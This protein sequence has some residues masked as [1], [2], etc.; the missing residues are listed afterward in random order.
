M[1][2]YD[3]LRS[4]LE[5]SATALAERAGSLNKRRTEV[6]GSSV[7]ALRG[8]ERLRS[9]NANVPRD[10]SSI[11]G[12][13][14][15]AYNPAP[16]ALTSVK[17]NDIFAIHNL[18]RSSSGEMVL[19]AN[20]NGL[21]A[22]V[23]DDAQFRRDFDELHTYYK[24][25]RVQQLYRVANRMLAVF[26]IGT[27]RSDIRVL[28]WSVNP[29][30]S[31]Q[32]LD[33]RGERDHKAPARHDV[34][35]TLVTREDHVG[36]SHVSLSDRVLINPLNGTI[37]LMMPDRSLLLSDPVNHADQSLADCTIRWA[38]CGD[39]IV[40]DLLPYGEL[41]HRYYVANLLDHTATRID[42]LGQAFRQLPEGQG[43]IHPRGVFLKNGQ[44]QSF[45]LEADQMEL[46]EVVRSPNGEDMLYVFYEQESGRSILL[47]Y[48]VVRQEVTTP[49]RCDGHS[50]FADGTMVM[51]REEHEPTRI[52]PMQI[53]ETPFASDEWFAAQPREISDLDRI[54][55]AA[56]VRGIADALALSRLIGSIEPSSELYG[57][58]LGSV[59]RFLDQHHWAESVD[60]G[61]LA[62]PAR[63]MQ[64]VAGQVIDE[65]E[66]VLE[67]KAVATAT[68]DEA[69]QTFNQHH[70]EERISPPATTEAFINLLGL[71]R[72]D[73]GHLHSI[74]DQP[75]VDVAAVD[76]LV[77]EATAAHAATAQKAAGHLAGDGAFAPYHER[78]ARITGS[79]D[80]AGSSI[81]A[82]ELLEEVDGVAT[83][84]DV[85]SS[86]V[87]DL[88]VDDPRVRTSVLEQVSQ[89]LASLNQVRARVETKQESLI[90][91]ETGAS[92]ATELGLF[93][94]SI[95]SALSRVDEPKGCDE[96]LGRLLLQLEQ[97]ETAGPRSDEQIREL[98]LRREQV[99]ETVSARRQKLVDEREAKAQRLVG[100]A[101]R[102]L[103][104]ITERAA[105]LPSVDDVNGFFAADPMTARVR[106]LTDQLRELG[107]A[108]KA[109]ELKSQLGAARD[110]A[111]RLILDRAELF[112]GEL[113]K[114]GRHRFSVDKQRRELTIV[115]RDGRLQAVLTGTDFALDL[116]DERLE[117]HRDLWSEPLVSES[118]DLYRGA[119]LAAGILDDALSSGQVPMWEDVV[120][121]AV[122]SRLDEGY[123]R[124]VHDH[125][126]VLLVSA[127]A[128]GAA[129][130]GP[131]LYPS[132]VRAEALWHWFDELSEEQRV[133]WIGRGKA[134][135]ELG[136]AVEP[137]L[138]SYMADELTASAGFAPSMSHETA[139]H[140]RLF[141]GD[142]KVQSVLTSAS[143]NPRAYREVLERYVA[144]SAPYDIAAEIVVTLLFPEPERRIRTIDL[145]CTVSGLLGRHPTIQDGTLRV[146]LDELLDLSRHQRNDVAPRHRAFV[147]ARREIVDQL[148]GNLR[149]HDLVPHVPEGF[150]R[151]RLIDEVYLPLIGGNLARQIGTVDDTSAARSGLLMLLSPPGYGKTTLIEYV[152]DRLGMALVKVSGP[153]LG[154]D[155]TS[156][157]PAQAASSTSRR[158]LDRI[159]MAFAIA[160]NVILYIDDIQHTNPE[161]LQ[162]FI[163]LTDA[164][165]RVEGVL[166]GE[167]RTF[168]LRGKR[169]AVVM[170]G[171]PYTESGERF[172][173]PDMLAN[174]AD[175][176]NLGDVLAD[177]ERAFALSYIENSLTS[178][179]AVTRIGR[180]LDAFMAGLDGGSVD[181]AALTQRYSAA[182]QNDI[183]RLLHHLRTVQ[184][185]VLTVNRQY[186]ASAAT[187][188]AY[189]TEPPFLL[190]GSYRNMTRLAAQLLPAMTEDE[191]EEILDAHY[192][193]ESQSL[194]G[195]A[196][197]NLLKL[198]QLRGKMTPT[199]E[200][201]W[202][203]IIT[204]FQRK[205]RLGGG[206]DDPVARVV[207]AI[208]QVSDALS[209]RVNHSPYD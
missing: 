168:D 154:H 156:L 68:L 118:R 152:A 89:V 200:T 113:I 99:T 49:L 180:D 82:R 116:H 85:V 70:E 164:Q 19:N 11:D 172:R 166:E 205:Q 67:V 96:A 38:T 160:S 58:L 110:N 155:V 144:A 50:I 171:N 149:V 52:H 107:E 133:D 51:F 130:A 36:E 178:N 151:N 43:F 93:G 41:D 56:L 117:A 20:P 105:A 142:Q 16:G 69:R 100:A 102:T 106:D 190:Q 173:I 140:V 1:S 123:D 201:R 134:A 153:G 174:R 111:A 196:E 44:H 92:F 74:R 46:L 90:E 80:E 2:T 42:E 124:G 73:L 65:F 108:V 8:T 104:R 141:S 40:I 79:I 63:E 121:E 98:E 25:A 161:F 126:A 132:R 103:E 60:V 157:D 159:N 18:E 146:S 109:D 77:T 203:E 207:A 76:E 91:A 191:V 101:E 75:E 148:K 206:D 86:T 33:A 193:A 136:Q 182:E 162:R 59:G 138:G 165:R 195:A 37:E 6:F 177:S 95:A 47:P 29:D 204:V 186:I 129:T 54:G 9:E 188:D 187:G 31:L 114:L 87:G 181:E 209:G 83:S 45:D 78:L 120:R 55:N 53:W 64:V 199:Q 119:Y 189:R 125:D 24:D 5:A 147:A 185:T 10:V 176:Y 71:Y 128:A 81:A 127:W 179:P 170:A 62:E 12:Q 23:L 57:D 139:R 197:A 145:D 39:L 169:F 14:I 202:N 88:V 184:Q 48:N 21:D 150:V 131:L 7:F 112:D 94:Q 4:R 135:A 137:V 72:H 15:V 194:T 3:L 22:S 122:D 158:E 66:R 143:Q 35:W 175:T 167:S 28:R 84:M 17:P 30:G 26:R 34:D 163:S 115:P 192:T 198:A 32:Y 13:L 97:L 27:A 61:N 183:V 208:D